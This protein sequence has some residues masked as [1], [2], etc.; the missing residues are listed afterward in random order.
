MNNQ[1]RKLRNSFIRPSKNKIL[2][3]KTNQRDKTVVCLKLLSNA[4]EILKDTN[5]WKHSYIHGLECNID[6]NSNTK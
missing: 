4:E 6:I 2:S 3:N 1:K 5:K